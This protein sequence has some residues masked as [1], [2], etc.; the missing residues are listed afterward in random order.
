MSVALAAVEELPLAE[1]QLSALQERLA[2]AIRAVIPLR[3]L[4]TPQP[5]QAGVVGPLLL[6]QTLRQ[7]LVVAG[8]TG[9]RHQS[10]GRL[11]FV[12]LEAAAREP[13]RRAQVD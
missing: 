12:R 1:C 6:E 3:T 2:K 5:E 7:V 9:L 4:I 10:Q 11:C 8:A 13:Q